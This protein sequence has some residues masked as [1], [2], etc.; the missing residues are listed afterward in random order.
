MLGIGAPETRHHHPP[1]PFFMP[2]R[3]VLPGQTEDWGAN[4]E[5]L[6]VC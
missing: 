1:M 6:H 5:T 3:L 2:A 4:Q